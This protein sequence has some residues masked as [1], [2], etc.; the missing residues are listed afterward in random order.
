[1]FSV[2]CKATQPS[3]LDLVPVSRRH[4]LNS[5]H[6]SRLSA[7]PARYI[8][9]NWYNQLKTADSVVMFA[10]WSIQVDFAQCLE[11]NCIPL[12]TAVYFVCSADPAYILPDWTTNMKPL[13][14]EWCLL[15]SA[16]L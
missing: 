10:K 6:S 4:S 11:D 2:V 12:N 14:V 5:K 7:S 13:I 1:M 15:S 3:G 9:Q 8:L 16:S